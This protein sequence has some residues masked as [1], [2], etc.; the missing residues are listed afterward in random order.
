MSKKYEVTNNKTKKRYVIDWD[1]P[2]PPTDTDFDEIFSKQPQTPP[3]AP[4]TTF[5]TSINK[6]GFMERMAPAFEYMDP[7]KS[8]PMAMVPPIDPNEGYLKSAAKMAARGIDQYAFGMGEQLYNKGKEMFGQA[9]D[10]W[11]SPL[12]AQPLMATRYGMKNAMG[13]VGGDYDALEADILQK[14]IPGALGDVAAPIGLGVLMHGLGK[15]VTRGVPAE[16]LP[17]TPKVNVVPPVTPPIQ[18]IRGLLKAPTDFVSHPSGKIGRTLDPNI[19]EAFAAEG[20]ERPGTTLRDIDLRPDQYTSV[21][22]TPGELPPVEPIT[23]PEPYAPPRTQGIGVRP[24]VEAPTRKVKVVYRDET[25]KVRVRTENLPIGMGETAAEA[26]RHKK[27][28]GE[29]ISADW[30]DEHPLYSHVPNVLRPEAP[31]VA[32]L[33]RLAEPVIPKGET[34]FVSGPREAWGNEPRTVK[35]GSSILTKEERARIREANKLNY[36]KE[37]S[38]PSAERTGLIETVTQQGRPVSLLDRRKLMEA[39]K[40]KAE[41][42]PVEPIIK[43]PKVH[44]TV[45]SIIEEKKA[46]HSADVIEAAKKSLPDRFRNSAIY[47]SLYEPIAVSSLTRLKKM[48]AS[49]ETLA[50]LLKDERTESH[51]LGGEHELKTREVIRS[52]SKEEQIEVVKILD[53]QKSI[54]D[55]SNQKV[56]DAFTSLR[57]STEQLGDLAVA[58]NVRMKSSEGLN[59]PFQKFKGEYFPHRYPEELFKDPVALREK[60]LKAGN[61][62]VAV[63]IMMKRITEQGERFSS[64]QHARDFN[65]PGYKESLESLSEHQ[66]EMARVITR[67]ERFGPMDVADPNSHISRLIAKT[68]NPIEAQKIV[69]DYLSRIDYGPG[70]ESQH[71]VYNAVVKAEVASKLSQ[72]GITNM[73]DLASVS[74]ALGIKNLT[75]AI[76]RTIFDPHGSADIST[77]SGS[78]AILKDELHR[79]VGQGNLLGKAYGTTSTEKFIRTVGTLAGRAEVQRLFNL[80]KKDSR[81][82]KTLA[83]FVDGDVTEVLKQNKLTDKQID[84][85]GGRAVELSSGIPDKLGLSKAMF[86]DNPL[87]RLPFLFKRFA[88]LN[89]RNMVDAVNRQPT[90]AG[91]LA[92]ATML[93]GAYQVAGEVI[94]DTKAAIKGLINGDVEKS[95]EER[96]DYISSGNKAFDRILANFLQSAL[97]GIVGD[98]SESVVRKSVGKVS[99]TALGPVGSDVDELAGIAGDIGEGKFT[100][101]GKGVVRRIP[102]IGAGLAEKFYDGKKNPFAL[103]PTEHRPYQPT[104]R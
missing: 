93:I 69:N 14:N 65:L 75:K 41:L 38:L 1:G 101:L 19:P 82:A 18:S 5:S 86:A 2:S 97:F 94:G 12:A 28:S 100:S 34:Q 7:K 20:L 25:G 32:G 68:S 31:N 43:E 21:Y 64:A 72:F 35:I 57:Q 80:A 55:A 73:G 58:A 45:E 11:N 29:I 88:F 60:L 102:Y 85:A 87:L 56:K 24:T 36:T 46:K 6:P 51:R 33:R 16:A 98:V 30:L 22:A 96:G 10:V 92:K 70:K 26:I 67:A 42:P 89:T 40:A 53:G 15:N 3:P 95:I 79:D 27:I 74:T 90:Y 17:Q 44:P 91:K 4:P 8:N 52:L 81:Y 39:A 9:K 49:G 37:P 54:N 63:D 77:R 48:G 99:G 83:D 13:L 47:K 103:K 104:S 76:A 62:P 23:T 84:F 59:V 50:K 71:K 66:R 78:L 61:S